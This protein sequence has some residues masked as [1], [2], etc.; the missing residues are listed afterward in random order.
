[1]EQRIL[2]CEDS[3]T[4]I[5]TGIYEAYGTAHRERL[6]LTDISLQI[7]EEADAWLFASY[8]K[9]VPDEAAAEKVIR[10]LKKRFGW[11][12]YEALCMA[13]TAPDREKAQA[14]YRT[15]AWGLKNAAKGHLLDH[16]TDP[17]VHKVLT[18]SRTASCENHHLMGFLRFKELE[19]RVLY[20]NMQPKNDILPFLAEHF[21]DR[22]PGENFLIRDE[23]R[24]LFAV[25]PAGKPWFLLR[26]AKEEILP[27][28]DAYETAG[29]EAYYQELFRQFCHT[30]SIKDRENLKL[31]QNLLPLRFRSFMMEF[32]EN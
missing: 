27:A 29:E 2:I 15:V 22:L 8:R 17:Y 6:A 31:Q 11:D 16:L 5:F 32:T 9:I 30:I 13:L 21:A 4:G 3:L 7:G 20:A 10:T 19:G 25:H 18:L 26:A 28:E 24:N 14:V 23:G 1:M 12:D